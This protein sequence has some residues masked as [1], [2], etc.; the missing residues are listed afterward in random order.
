MSL[1]PLRV[2]FRYQRPYNI[3]D[4][5][6]VSHVE[7]DPDVKG[8]RGWVVENV[9]LFET[10]AFWTPTKEHCSLS[11]GSLANSRII[12]AARS[13]QGVFHILLKFPIDTPYDKIQIFKTAVEEY[14]KARPRGE[15]A[16]IL[17]SFV[18]VVAVCFLTSFDSFSG[19]VEWLCLTAFR[20][21]RIET[22]QS[23]IEYD[24]VVTHR[25][26]WQAIGVVSSRLVLPTSCK[27]HS[28]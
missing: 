5:I 2:P 1:Y 16:C 19:T 27:L 26:S 14:L 7:R 8:S 18:V 17:V 3:G 13:P 10:T 20:A 12:N 21:T 11:N 4:R 22:E 6:H 23:F 24:L 15:F 25:E 9:T 28:T